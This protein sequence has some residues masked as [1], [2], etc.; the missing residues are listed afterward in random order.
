[1][2]NCH[3]TKRFGA[4]A[5]NDIPRGRNLALQNLA[6]ELVS[7]DRVV[8]GKD[9]TYCYQVLEYGDSFASI[10]L[11]ARSIWKRGFNLLVKLY[12]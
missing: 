7:S 2:L 3:K 9:M 12:V 4:S 1:M 10:P 11:T 6:I 5:Y 8:A